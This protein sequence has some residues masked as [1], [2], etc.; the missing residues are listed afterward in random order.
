MPSS[1]EDVS[2]QCKIG[3]VF[4]ARWQ[5]QS[6][7]VGIWNA[8]VLS[9]S[10]LHRMLVKML[11]NHRGDTG[12]VWTHGDV[13]ICTTCKTLVDADAESS[14]AFLAVATP[15][16]GDIERHDDAVAFLE[17]GDA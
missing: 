10:T 7:E 5:F 16:A 15:S 4:G 17:Q 6:V 14:L 8:D 11:W 9:L 12:L 2:K 1:G 13:S 3:L